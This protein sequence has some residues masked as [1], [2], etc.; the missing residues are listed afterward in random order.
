MENIY[1]KKYQVSPIDTDFS[2]KLKTEAL[3]NYLM[4]M[5]AEHAARL[6]VSVVDMFKLN[7]TWVLSRYHVQ[8]FRYPAM[9]EHMTVSTWPATGKGTFA[10]REFEVKDAEG[11]IAKATT[12]WLAL[13]LKTKRPVKMESFL[14]DM[15]VHSQRALPDGFKSL[16]NVNQAEWEKEF[17]VFRSHLDMNRHVTSNVYIQWALETVPEKILLRMYPTGIEVN[18]RA[19]A[20]YGDRILSRVQS[21]EKGERT[22][23]V[24]Q[25]HRAKDGIELARLRTFWQTLSADS[26]SKEE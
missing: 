12:S 3:L 5:A 18:Y 7:L 8:I 19:E 16:P 2:G 11:E 9:G 25:L 6:G 24:H 14:P 13:N 17:P 23:F 1:Q 15:P 20:F 26:D 4:E 21:L 10:L 22:G